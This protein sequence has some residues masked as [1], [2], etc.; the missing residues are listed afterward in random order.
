MKGEKKEKTTKHKNKEIKLEFIKYYSLKHW[1]DI[2][3]E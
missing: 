1:K 2:R 3:N